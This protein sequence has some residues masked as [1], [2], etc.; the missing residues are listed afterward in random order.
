MKCVNKV[1]AGRSP[2]ERYI[3]NRSKI[4]ARVKNYTKNNKQKVNNY[5]A[6]YREKNKNKF[7]IKFTCECGSILRK[8]GKNRHLK[9]KKH[10][11]YVNNLK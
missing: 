7:K 5:Q 3:D 6:K 1:I 11:D 9:T 2:V 4:I 8:Y 10:I